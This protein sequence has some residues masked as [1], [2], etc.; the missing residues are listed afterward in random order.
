[1][2][3]PFRVVAACTLLTVLAG[4]GGADDEAVAPVMPDVVGRQLDVALST[5][6][7]A[8]FSEEVEVTGGGTFGIVDTSNW[9]VC[10]QSPAAGRPFGTAPNLT[11]DR[12]CGDDA[13]S[14]TEPPDTTTEA[15]EPPDP[16]TSTTAKAQEVLTSANNTDLSALLSEPN[17]CSEKIQSFAST[18]AG[19]T[20]EFDGNVANL[21]NHGDAETRFDILVSPGE[22]S[23]SSAIGP[24]FQF[25]DVNILDLNLTGPDAPDSVRQ[26]DNLHF[27][28]QI[29]GYEP[30]SCL[31]FLDPVSTAAR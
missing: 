16:T 27:V 30:T 20:I 7:S 17:D 6:E 3:N 14:T 12:S 24:S 10:E 22:F 5:V 18:Y 25:R 8:G 13:E 28:A 26:G 31:F 29:Q 2:T 23:T 4:C 1:M 19:R 11:V 15:T 21:A 9:T